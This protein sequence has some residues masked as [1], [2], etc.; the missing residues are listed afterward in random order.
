MKIELHE[1][2]MRI[3]FRVNEDQTVELVDFSAAADAADLKPLGPNGAADGKQVIA[4]RQF[5]AVNVT[6]ENAYTVK[7]DGGSVSKKWHY[8]SHTDRKSVV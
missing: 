8:G 1:A 4:P 2:G 5:L 3:A 7:H 6:G